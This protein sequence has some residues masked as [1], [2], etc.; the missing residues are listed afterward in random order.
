M[1]ALGAA[2]ACASPVLSTQEVA[3]SVLMERAT[4]EGSERGE[5]LVRSPVRLPLPALSE[6]RHGAQLLARFGFT[7]AEIEAAR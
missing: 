6:E 7:R 2:D 3:E 4:R 1:A 5:K